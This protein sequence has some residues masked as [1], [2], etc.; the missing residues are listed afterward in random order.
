MTDKIVVLS[1]CESHAEA[2]KIARH[3]VEK[4][5]AACVTVVPAAESIYHWQGRL[6]VAAECLLIIKSSRER[7]AALKTELQKVHSYQV[8]EI[9]AMQI[10]DGSEAYLAW[11]DRELGQQ[12]T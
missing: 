7:L 3:L 2:S 5:V 9:V 1:T 11:M 8:P 4:R 10:V 12:S 6:E